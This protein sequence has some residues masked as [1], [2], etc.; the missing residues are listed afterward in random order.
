MTDPVLTAAR[1]VAIDAFDE[2][3][4]V[5]DGIPADALDWRPAGP[6][7]NSIAVL[8][9]HSMNST[10]L[11]LRVAAGLPLP[12][13]DRNAEFGAKSNDPAALLRLIDDLAA[14]C[15][16][17]LDTTEPIDWGALHPWKRASGEVVEFTAAYALIHG[18]EHLRGHTDQ[19]SLTR[20][21]WEGRG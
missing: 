19:A 4:R 11:W 21:L 7:T 17:S 14:D 9:T 6:E 2:L 15:M 12:A 1:K 20:H 16:A 8:V 3:R 13:R 10:R 5:I 18:V